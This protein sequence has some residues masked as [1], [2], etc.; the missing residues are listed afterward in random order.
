MTSSGVV[1][2]ACYREVAVLHCDRLPVHRTLAGL[3]RADQYILHLAPHRRPRDIVPHHRLA[4]VHSSDV[5]TVRHCNL[6]VDAPGVLR[7]ATRS[8]AIEV[9]DA[10]PVVPVEAASAAG[11][12]DVCV[13]FTIPAVVEATV[14]VALESGAVVEDSAWGRFRRHFCTEVK[15]NRVNL[16]LLLG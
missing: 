6:P 13:S 14:A 16:R 10:K 3:R 12:V 7:R 15:L 5:V 4:K 1:R 2:V 11:V 9:V 8:I